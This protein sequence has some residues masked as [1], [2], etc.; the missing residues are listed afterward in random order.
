[1]VRPTYEE[2]FEEFD[3]PQRPVVITGATATWR[4]TGLWTH[5]WFARQYGSVQVA[6]SREKTHTTKV[7]SLQLA[8]Y[9]ELIAE[10]KDRGLYM[11]QFNVDRIPGLAD[12]IETPYVHPQ[13]RNVELNLWV[14]PAGTMISLHK[15]NHNGFDY[16]NNIFA[17]VC[18]R[19]RAV[20]ASPDQD[21]LMYPRTKEQGAHWHSQVDWE[22]PD[23]A[24]FPRFREVVLQETVLEPGELLFIPG[25]YWHSL[26]S[27]D[28]SISV[29]CWW[30]V[31]RIADVVVTAIARQKNPSLPVDR[32]TRD[33]V[34][35]YGGIAVVGEVLRTEL[36]EGM[37]DLIWSILEPDVQHALRAWSAEHSTAREVTDMAA[38]RGLTC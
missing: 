30:R 21:P 37:R 10:G 5:D 33:D 16:A 25:N 11:D 15:D 1:M 38:A 22:S 13:R 9:I 20:L 34:E 18:G 4:A 2:F 6:L 12:D 17:Q 14:G 26:R 3:R 28:P 36:P 19:K 27:L 8:K 29:S 7:A 31:H 32:I 24:R 35:A 23:Y